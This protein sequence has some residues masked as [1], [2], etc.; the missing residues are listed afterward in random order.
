MGIHDDL[1]RPK[2]LT[3]SLMPTCSPG[4]LPLPWTGCHWIAGI[5]GP[6]PDERSLS[7]RAIPMTPTAIFATGFSSS[8]CPLTARVCC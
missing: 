1:P 6:S 2:I 3:E 4:I 7:G 5:G 8:L